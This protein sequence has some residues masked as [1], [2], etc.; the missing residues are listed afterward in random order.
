MQT[1]ELSLVGVDLIRKGSETVKMSEAA[2]V[3]EKVEGMIKQL[4]ELQLM[5]VVT[6]LGLTVKDTKK[7][8]KEAMQSVVKRH[9]SSEEIE[10]SQDEGLAV[11]QKLEGELQA[12]LADSL[13]DADDKTQIEILKKT[14][15]ELLRRDK[16]KSIK[17]ENG[18]SGSGGG[19]AT[20]SQG[21][22]VRN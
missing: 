2:T 1:A 9:L 11:F 22:R 17:S 20:D 5:Q 21:R 7:S 6:S 13:E 8:K 12:I 16:G 3:K 14:V 18:S 19:G 15:D 10:D 4:D